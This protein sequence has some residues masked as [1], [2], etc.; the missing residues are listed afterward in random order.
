MNAQDGNIT[1]RRTE[2]WRACFEIDA[3]KQQFT[4]MLKPLP[5]SFQAYRAAATLERWK[6]IGD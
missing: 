1:N 4:A 2:Y 5:S 6:S 3:L